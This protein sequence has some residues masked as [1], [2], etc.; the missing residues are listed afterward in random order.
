MKAYVLTT[1]IVFALIVV[2]HTVR[3]FAEGPHLIME[4]SFAFTSALAIALFV[5]ACRLFLRLSRSRENT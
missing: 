4:P 3:I 2:A 1:G 5:W